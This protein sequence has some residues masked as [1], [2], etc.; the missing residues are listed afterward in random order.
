MMREKFY[1]TQIP[2][3]QILINILLKISLPKCKMISNL[4]QIHA[5][6]RLEYEE[7][8]YV[9]CLFHAVVFLLL[10]NLALLATTFDQTLHFNVIKMLI[11]L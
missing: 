3:F 5:I 4:K 6:E 10:F 1:A 7:Q 11:A 8:N 9:A 2:E